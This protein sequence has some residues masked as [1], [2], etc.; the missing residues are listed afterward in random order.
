MSSERKNLPP[1]QLTLE[2]LALIAREVTL[3]QGSHL[4]MIVVQG[5]DGS[6]IAELEDMPSTHEARAQLLYSLGFNLG[7]ERKFGQLKQVFMTTEAW[8]SMGSKDAPPVM[9]PSQDPN[10]KEVLII[11]SFK[12]ED[13]SAGILMYEMIRED[14]KLVDLKELHPVSEGEGIAHNPLLEAFAAGYIRGSE[15][16]LN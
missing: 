13:R 5:K 6:M 9:P 3:K 7:Q 16:P 2:T 15:V 14:E 12:L 1:S 11:S 4:P 10:R 8:L